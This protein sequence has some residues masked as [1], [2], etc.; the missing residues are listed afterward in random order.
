MDLDHVQIEIRPRKPFEG[1]DLGFRMG[2]AWFLTLWML[3]LGTAVPLILLLWVTLKGYPV[4]LMLVVWWLK[5]VYETPILYWLSRAIFNERP[6]IRQVLKKSYTI[7]KPQL[8]SRLT[9]RRW[10]PSRSFFMPVLM[11]ENLRGKDYRDRTSILGHNQSAGYTL[12]FVCFLFEI[13]LYLSGIMLILILVPEEIDF[14]SF[15][16]FFDD[17]SIGSLFTELVL[18]TLTMSVIA[19]FYIAAGFSLYLTRRTELEAWDIELNFK[20]LVRRK[21]ETE[22]KKSVFLGLLMML[23][24]GS[25]IF[26]TG[27]GY[28]SGKETARKTIENVLQHEDFGKTEK[29]EQWQLKNFSPEKKD[30]DPPEFFKILEAAG[31]FLAMLIRPLIWLAAG[32]LI[33]VILYYILKKT[34]FLE[35]FFTDRKRYVPPEELFG[36]KMTK[37]SLPENIPEEVR[38]LLGLGDVRG[39]LSLLYRGAL[40]RL[41][42]N[43]RMEISA[44]AT[45]GECVRLVETNRGPREF[46][47]FKGLTTIW[48]RMAYG[49]IRPSSAELEI[50]LEGWKKIYAGGPEDA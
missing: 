50:L 42:Y 18:F 28:A 40:Y 13:M 30:T 9:F 26:S 16:F 20:R 29:V 11:L 35:G 47:Y 33:A 45:E 34:D 8:F 43:A 37:A 32:V 23:V 31:R 22:A 7:I 10:S 15:G 4:L 36:L 3:W 1:L 24:A 39:A 27:N 38:R 17:T 41:V 21:K 19:P 14:I 12:T 25:L 2:S 6:G 46:E 5:P 48:L 44:S 49:H